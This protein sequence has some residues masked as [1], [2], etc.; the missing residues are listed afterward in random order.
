MTEDYKP[1]DNGIAERVNGI[2]KGESVYRQNRCFHSYEEALKQTKRFILFYNGQRP[3][4]SI[5]M[6]TPD[7]AHK[8]T[9]KQQRMWKKKIYLKKKYEC[10][11]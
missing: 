2:I 1:T 10:A 3:H 4:Y 7:D 11:N 5:G 6:Q 9:G 8:Q